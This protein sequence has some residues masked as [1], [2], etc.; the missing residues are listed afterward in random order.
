MRTIGVV[1]AAADDIAII[2]RKLASAAHLSPALLHFNSIPR[3]QLKLANCVIV[4]AAE[5]ATDVVID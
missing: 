1:R 4:P 2:L 3:L 5:I